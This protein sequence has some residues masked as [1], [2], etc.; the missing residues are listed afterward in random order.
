[1]AVLKKIGIMSLAKLYA[2]IMA[3]AGLLVG[4]F[5]A[6]TISTGFRGHMGPFFRLGYSAVIALPILYAAIG[7]LFGAIGAAV[8]NIIADLVGGVELELENPQEKPK[9]RATRKD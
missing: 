4:V 2:V 3:F 6:T 1:M 5:V 7:F 9:K 8:Y